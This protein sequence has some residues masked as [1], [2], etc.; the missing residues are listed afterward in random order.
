MPRHFPTK[1]TALIAAIAVLSGAFNIAPLSPFS[2]SV[3]QVS[4]A[5]E[6]CISSITYDDPAAAVTAGSDIYN[7]DEVYKPGTWKKDWND[8][9]PWGNEALRG[10]DIAYWNEVFVTESKPGFTMFS[11]RNYRM[12]AI[13][14]TKSGKVYWHKDVRNTAQH[15]WSEVT[16]PWTKPVLFAQLGRYSG[17]SAPGFTPPAL[18]VAI[19]AGDDVFYS[20][21]LLS[22]AAWKTSANPEPWGASAIESLALSQ[23]GTSAV[24]IANRRVYHIGTAALGIAYGRSPSPYDWKLMRQTT[25]WWSKPIPAPIHLDFV[26]YYNHMFV[27]S[28]EHKVFSHAPWTGMR[29]IM[30]S[31]QWGD[32]PIAGVAVSPI[33]RADRDSI[34][35]YLITAGNRVYRATWDWE[36]KGKQW[37][38]VTGNLLTELN[39]DASLATNNLK[40]TLTGDPILK[41]SGSTAVRLTIENDSDTVARNIVFK[42][43]LRVE[44]AV[45]YAPKDVNGV[46]APLQGLLGTKCEW[47]A[48][49]ESQRTINSYYDT[50]WYQCAVDP[51]AARATRILDIP[52]YTRNSNNTSNTSTCEEGVM[53]AITISLLRSNDPNGSGK[54]ATVSGVQ[55]SCAKPLCS[56]GIDNDQD[57]LIDANDSG[58]DDANG[59]YQPNRYTEGGTVAAS[60]S[61]SSS[62]AASSAGASQGSQVFF[63]W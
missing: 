32:Q 63:L 17:V 44:G 10:V 41:R 20:P 51:I 1:L 16:G 31:D 45:L 61:S 46:Y 50:N 52:V 22:N 55:L 49:P 57:G 38:D 23:D 37:T 3:P 39:C 14:V 48:L 30:G 6:S 34:A 33:S 54:Q 9:R 36:W 28:Y 53:G 56:D 58:C 25:D 40:L 60:S 11:N 8:N 13:V 19:A 7:N 4:A 35:N 29:D 2:A 18:H 24:V 27:S 42:M 62:N 15:D 59:V 5:G 43:P 12:S 47:M 26:S 21:D